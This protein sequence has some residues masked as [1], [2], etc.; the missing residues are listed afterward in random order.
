MH[1]LGVS[2]EY[3]VR[4]RRDWLSCNWVSCTAGEKKAFL[5]SFNPVTFYLEDVLVFFVCWFIWPFNMIYV[6]TEIFTQF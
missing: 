6:H 1:Q 5:C 3:S 4:G 2:G